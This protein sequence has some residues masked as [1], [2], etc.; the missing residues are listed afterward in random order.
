MHGV[1]SMYGGVCGVE[2]SGQKKRQNTGKKPTSIDCFTFPSV[3]SDIPIRL[4]TP[5]MA[6]SVVTSRFPSWSWSPGFRPLP[7]WVVVSALRPEKE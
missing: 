1:A 4:W 6:M 2:A 7:R 3:G 5:L